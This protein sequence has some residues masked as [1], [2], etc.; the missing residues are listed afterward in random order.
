MKPTGNRLAP[1]RRRGGGGK[2]KQEKDGEKRAQAYRPV[3]PHHDKSARH[4][5][6][7]NDEPLA[8]MVRRF[9]R[10]DGGD[11]DAPVENGAEE[12]D[13]GATKPELFLNQRDQGRNSQMNNGHAY[14]GQGRD[15]EEKPALFRAL[16]AWMH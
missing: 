11:D 3:H 10:R 12:P 8:E 4:R 16:R 1:G 5:P 6:I 9:S 14:L 13:F 15:K 2:S 7:G